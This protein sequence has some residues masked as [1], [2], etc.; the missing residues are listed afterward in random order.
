MHV[1]VAGATGV[2][3]RSL[4]PQ[5]LEEGHEVSALARVG[6]GHLLPHGAHAVAG[7]VLDREWLIR[8]LNALKPDV[9]INQLT[10]L[11]DSL[12]AWELDKIYAQNDLV[13]REGTKNLLDAALSC[14]ARRLVVQSSAYWYAPW[15]RR[16]K[17]EDDVLW[18]TAPDPIGEAARTT[19]A[20]EEM[21]LTT[22]GV[23]GVALR[24]G[25]LY[26]PGT[27][28]AFDGDIGRRVRK[29]KYPIIGDGSGEMSFIHVD[30]AASAAV[31][32]LKAPPGVYNVVDDEPA[33]ARDWLP[34]YAEALGAEPPK[35]IAA[36]V[37]E[38][39]VGTP[40]VTWLTSEQ[41]A[42]NS[43]AK[44]QLEWKP[45]HSSWRTGFLHALT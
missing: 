30:D 25:Q 7:D 39:L 44:A 3:A 37:A 15:G 17:T 28:Y 20:V 16:A 35:H 9:I 6:R 38:L 29:G 27:W 10:R 13:R 12:R 21:V 18:V 1:F 26:G 23:E 34:L 2:I 40:L 36:G 22:P 8:R 4:I 14:G 24:Y 43:R 33:A 19:K 11:P 32:A 42:D 5:L 31:A 41:G 45:E